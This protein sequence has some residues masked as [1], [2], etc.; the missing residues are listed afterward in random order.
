MWF[1]NFIFCLLSFHFIHR[2]YLCYG[3]RQ[4]WYIRSFFRPKL[5]SHHVILHVSGYLCDTCPHSHIR[6]D[7]AT[8]Y[9]YIYIYLATLGHMVVAGHSQGQFWGWPNHP[10]GPK[11][12]FFFHFGLWGGRATPISAGLGVAEPLSWPSRVFRPPPGAKVERKKE[13]KKDLA[14]EGGRTT[15][16]QPL[17]CGPKW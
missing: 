3:K 11:L 17:S 1:P 12:F 7:V 4:K 9:I 10:H 6:A 2:R 5:T 8:I 16:R 13:K 14:F 15:P